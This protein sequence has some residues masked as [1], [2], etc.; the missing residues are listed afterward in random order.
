MW[1]SAMIDGGDGGDTDIEADSLEEAWEEAVAWAKEGTWPPEGTRVDVHVSSV[2]D[3]DDYRQKEIEIEPDED[4]LMAEAGADQNCAHEWTSEGEG[5]CD[6]NP[7]VW[8]L[9]GTAM[10]YA[11]HCK[12]CGLRKLTR[13]CGSQRNP[14]ECDT[15]RFELPEDWQI[16]EG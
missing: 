16:E 10:A 14:G 12:H 2:D 11:E 5:G 13:I 9:G 8:S 7:G 1:Y 3:P 4:A 6:T 15:V